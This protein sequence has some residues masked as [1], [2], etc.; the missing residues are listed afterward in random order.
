M[1]VNFPQ[2]TDGF[3]F[4]NLL[5]EREIKLYIYSVSCEL[6]I[7]QLEWPLEILG[8]LYIETGQQIQL[9][10]F[11]YTKKNNFYFDVNSYSLLS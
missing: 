10:A 11:V 3:N 7:M 5:N 4:A 8:C 6:S 1:F 9:S 2:Y